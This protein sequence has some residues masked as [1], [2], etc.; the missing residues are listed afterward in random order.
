MLQF[1]QQTCGTNLCHFGNEFFKP[2]T[3]P[4]TVRIQP[5]C[6]WEHPNHLMRL[7]TTECE[8]FFFLK[9]AFYL[10]FINC[11]LVRP[12]GFLHSQT[13]NTQF[14][15]DSQS[16]QG[17][18]SHSHIEFDICSNN[19]LETS[20]SESVV[21]IVPPSN[22]STADEGSFKL[23]GLVEEADARSKKLV[24]PMAT[25]QYACCR[26]GTNNLPWVKLDAFINGPDWNLEIHVWMNLPIVSKH[27]LTILWVLQDSVWHHR[28]K[29]EADLMVGLWKAVH[30]LCSITAPVNVL[31]GKIVQLVEFLPQVYPEMARAAGCW[32]VCSWG[33]Q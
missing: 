31:Q 12:G 18:S 27:H 4:S 1:W 2:H 13:T 10:Y 14:F 8:F 17:H 16:M 6:L 26:D 3:P 30:R 33:S 9:Y 25:I 19:S 20:D 29:E 23:K 5:L 24:V 32:E 7:P 15:G 22:K 28:C 11:K 21:E